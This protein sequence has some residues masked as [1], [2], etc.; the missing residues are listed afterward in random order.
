V[1]NPAPLQAS[2]AGIADRLGIPAPM[3]GEPPFLSRLES[4]A[5]TTLAD[6]AARSAIRFVQEI[7][8]SHA[9]NLLAAGRRI[10]ALRMLWRSR[11]AVTR[12]RWWTTAAMTLS[13]PARLA[14]ALHQ[15]Q[16]M[17]KSGTEL[18]DERSG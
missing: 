17:R 5:R 9:R 3:E 7:R 16:L 11:S 6:Q 12:H 13:L 15:R 4:R 18:F 1:F 10:Q 14:C 8:I 2:R